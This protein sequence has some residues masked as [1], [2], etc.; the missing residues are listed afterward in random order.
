MLRLATGLV[1]SFALAGSVMAQSADP[2]WLE[3]LT[4]QAEAQKQCKIAYLLRVHEG[5]VGGQKT[6]EARVQCED[7]RQFD[8][9][10]IGEVEQFTFKACDTQVC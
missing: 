8:A 4:F 7:G 10:R 1:L 6:Y 3:D 2:S 5:E 9:Q